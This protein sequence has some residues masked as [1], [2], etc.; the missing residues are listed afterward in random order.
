MSEGGLVAVQLLPDDMPPPSRPLFFTSRFSGRPSHDRLDRRGR[1]QRAGA[2]GCCRTPVGAVQM[3]SQSPQERVAEA[4][5]LTYEEIAR[6]PYLDCV[7][8]AGFVKGHPVDTLYV[9]LERDSESEPTTILLRPDEAQAI[10]WV[11]NG[12]LWSDQMR[13][14]LTDEEAQP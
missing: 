9:R 4:L 6:Q 7:F 1:H 13:R 8:S 5:T 3:T 11:L 10:C 12:A 2:V 14:L